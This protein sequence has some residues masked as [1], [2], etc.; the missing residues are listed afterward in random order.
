M[1]KQAA[2][3]FPLLN[4]RG[5]YNSMKDGSININRLWLWTICSVNAR[6]QKSCQTKER[7]G[8]YLNFFRKT[9]PLQDESLSRIDSG[10]VLIGR[11]WSIVHTCIINCQ[12]NHRGSTVEGFVSYKRTIYRLWLLWGFQMGKHTLMMLFVGSPTR[13]MQLAFR[14]LYNCHDE[15]SLLWNNLT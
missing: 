9:V 14:P 7:K 1:H 2:I 5:R 8:N 6:V 10:K 3:D 13:V 4:D 15:F 12:T 11:Q